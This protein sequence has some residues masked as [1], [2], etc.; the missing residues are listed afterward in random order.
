MHTATQEQDDYA[1]AMSFD[2]TAVSKLTNQNNGTRTDVYNSGAS[3]H[4]SPMKIRLLDFSN[5]LA[6][7]GL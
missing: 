1:F 3:M 5:K 4:M 7:N 2:S 6:R